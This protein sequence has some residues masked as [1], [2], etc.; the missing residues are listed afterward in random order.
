MKPACTSKMYKL[1]H[2]LQAQG[3]NAASYHAVTDS[4]HMYGFS[5]NTSTHY[6]I[7][8]NTPSGSLEMILYHEFLPYRYTETLPNAAGLTE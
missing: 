8:L 3:S 7:K 2:H 4:A 6:N 1:T 5:I